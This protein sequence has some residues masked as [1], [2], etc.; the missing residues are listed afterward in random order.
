M[1]VLSPTSSL[2]PHNQQTLEELQRLHSHPSEYPSI[3]HPLSHRYI[4]TNLIITDS[5]KVIESIKAFKRNSV[6][7]PDGFRSSHMQDFLD[8]SINFNLCNRLIYSITQLCNLI[9]EGA[10]PIALHQIFSSST[11]VAIKKP[12][13]HSLRPISI[14]LFFRRLIGKISVN[15]LR[16]VISGYLPPHQIGF[17][18]PFASES[19]VHCTRSFLSTIPPNHALLL[20]DFRNA[21]NFLC[22][23]AMFDAIFKY[24]PLMYNYAITCYGHRSIHY[25]GDK[26]VFSD[27]GTDQGDNLS[28]VYWS[29]TTKPL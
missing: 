14:S 26:L 28:G 8:Y 17:M 5:S 25:F 1:R 16:Q 29:L 19:A 13:S 18:C 20:I 15:N 23:S 9:L 10:L 4:S 6:C 24:L 7:G 2:A 11:L 22:R 21:F 12:Q 27:Q 3:N